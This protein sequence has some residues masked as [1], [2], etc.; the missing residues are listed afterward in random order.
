MQHCSGFPRVKSYNRWQILFYRFV[1][2]F[3]VKKCS[4]TTHVTWLSRSSSS[5]CSSYTNTDPTGV[6]ILWLGLCRYGTEKFNSNACSNY[7]GTAAL[8]NTAAVLSKM[9]FPHLTDSMLSHS[10]PPPR[11]CILTTAHHVVPHRSVSILKLRMDHCLAF[12]GSFAVRSWKESKIWAR[13]HAPFLRKRFDEYLP[14]LKDFLS[15]Q[16]SAQNASRLTNR[17]CIIHYVSE[18]VTVS[19]ITVP[20]QTT[21]FQIFAFICS[22]CHFLKQNTERI[23]DIVLFITSTQSQDNTSFLFSKMGSHI[24]CPFIVLQHPL[25]RQHYLFGRTARVRHLYLSLGIRLRNVFSV[26]YC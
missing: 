16:L 10:P 14:N 1:D 21:T 9:I 11:I 2:A 7:A 26:I 8:S 13:F 20:A 24:D 23:R 18:A 5:Q 12:F 15:E 4:H 6:F 19:A 22:I 17:F 3:S 25:Q